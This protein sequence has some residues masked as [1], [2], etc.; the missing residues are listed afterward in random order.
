MVTHTSKHDITKQKQKQKHYRLKFSPNFFPIDK[1]L[2]DIINNDIIDYLHKNLQLTIHDEIILL[3][4]SGWLNDQ[5]KVTMMQMLYVRKLQ[6]LGYQQHK[7]IIMGIVHRYL[8]KC[9]QH[10]SINN[11]HWI[12]VHIYTSTQDLHC[13]MVNVHLMTLVYFL[14]FCF[15]IILFK[16]L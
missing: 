14:I 15:N 8:S 2:N 16:F 11:N 10:V 13:T 9:L 6:P 5:H 12:L 4:P 3:N 7:Y 1:D